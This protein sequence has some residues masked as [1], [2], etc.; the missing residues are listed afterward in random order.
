[1][2]FKIM[3][4]DDM[5]LMELPNISAIYYGLYQSGYDYY[6]IE[7]SSEHIDSLRRYF[8]PGGFSEF[9]SCTKQRT[10]EI[11]PYWPRAAIL[12]T[13]SFYLR[14]DNSAFNDYELFREY[15]MSL[16]NISA[17]ERDDSLWSWIANFPG[18]LRA[19]IEN[20]NFS[21]YMIFEKEWLAEQNYTH[22]DELSLIKK[23]LE[24]C[25]SQYNSP[26]QDI[27]IC[28]NPI[29][30]VYSSDYHLVGS[31]FI[32]TSGAFRVDSIIHEFLHHV[33]HP[34][35]EREKTLILKNKPIDMYLDE[36]Y[37]LS[38]SDSGI[39]NAFEESVVRLLTEKIM[40]HEYPENLLTFVKNFVEL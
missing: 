37:Y 19:V 29:K 17:S 30:C 2:F 24:I 28:I 40:N 36:S 13:A 27:K 34:L 18:A 26:V 39:L 9:F 6:S 8:N 14:D 25:R 5:L 1:M 33:V 16:C 11:Y 38:G 20:D 3:K 15:I 23:C 22:R 10:C 32:F 4:S 31:S 35:V 12:E 7:R 21:E